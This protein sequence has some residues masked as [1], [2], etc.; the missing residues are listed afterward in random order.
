MTLG[1]S[2]PLSSKGKQQTKLGPI[3]K[4]RGFA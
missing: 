1:P 4:E 3:I 2:E